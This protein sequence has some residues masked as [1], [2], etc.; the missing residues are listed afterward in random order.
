MR[1]GIPT[2]RVNAFFIF[3]PI[4]KDVVLVVTAR[5]TPSSRVKGILFIE[6]SPDSFGGYFPASKRCSGA[7]QV[8]PGF[9]SAY[10]VE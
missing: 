10:L 2:A 8:D 4:L 5:I 6:I 1:S 7:I 9:L 3:A